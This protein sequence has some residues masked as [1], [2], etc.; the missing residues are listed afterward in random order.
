MANETNWSMGVGRKEHER[1]VVE[2]NELKK[3]IG[4]EKQIR[5]DGKTVLCFPEEMSPVEIGKRIIK[6]KRGT[7]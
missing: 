5:I 4:K 2:L 7:L 3:K 1:A 6:F